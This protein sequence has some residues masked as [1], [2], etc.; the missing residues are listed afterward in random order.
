MSRKYGRVLIVNLGD[1]TSQT[2]EID[3]E[4]LKKFIGG[5]GLSAYLYGKFVKGDIP[6]P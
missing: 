5:P 2:M 3:P 4:V 6:P 1:Q